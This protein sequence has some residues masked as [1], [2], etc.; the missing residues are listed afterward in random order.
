MQING[1]LINAGL[2]HNPNAIYNWCTRKT[3][4]IEILIASDL[5]LVHWLKLLFATDAMDDNSLG[6]HCF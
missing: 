5:S 6:A 3:D 4:L 2:R 1:K